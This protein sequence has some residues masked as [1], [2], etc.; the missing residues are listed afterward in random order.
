M[1][2]TVKKALKTGQ[3]YINIPVFI[4]MFGS[5]I[6]LFYLSAIKKIPFWFGPLSFLIGP[7]LGW[8]YWS[9]A[10][11]KWKLWAYKNVRNVHELKEKAIRVGLIWNDESFFNK[12]EVWV[13]SQKKEWKIVKQK[14]NKKDIIKDDK[15]VPY[16]TIIKFSK[17]SF[18]INIV[19]ACFLLFLSFYLYNEN[20][21]FDFTIIL[22]ILFSFYSFFNSIKKY[23]TN[24]LIKLNEIGLETVDLG[25]IPWKRIN[26]IKVV[27]TGLGKSTTFNLTFNYKIKNDVFDAKIN[28][29]NLSKSFE[30]IEDLIKIYRKRYK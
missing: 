2:I 17:I 9:Y 19:S 28:L 30:E 27:K 10:I 5:M 26:N 24:L 22:F 6:L 7:F 12:T 18:W 1:S 4:I 23:R 29:D 11:V 25:F 21:S 13:N 15:N 3:I 8:I 14:F 16:E 20:K